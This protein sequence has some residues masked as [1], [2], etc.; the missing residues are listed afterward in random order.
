MLLWLLMKG[1]YLD[2]TDRTYSLDTD[3]ENRKDTNEEHLDGGEA[4]LDGY[5]GA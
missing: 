3:G 1:Y 2:D 4:C 5:F